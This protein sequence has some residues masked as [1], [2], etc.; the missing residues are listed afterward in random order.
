MVKNKKEKGSRNEQ[1]TAMRLAEQN[2]YTIRSSGSHGDIDV[3]GIYFGQYLGEPILRL[4]QSKSNG[5]YGEHDVEALRSHLN[6]MREDIVIKNLVRFELWDWID[7]QR[8]PIITVIGLRK[9]DDF[10]L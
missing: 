3:V 2:Y 10:I 6:L 8:E 7:Y 1:K 5:H 4:V 9:E